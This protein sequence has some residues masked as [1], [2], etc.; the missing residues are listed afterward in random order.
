MQGCSLSTASQK[1]WRQSVKELDRIKENDTE[2]KPGRLSEEGRRWG[3]GTLE[4]CNK[5]IEID[6]ISKIYIVLG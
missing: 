4:N 3:E 6:T 5:N 2:I 1:R